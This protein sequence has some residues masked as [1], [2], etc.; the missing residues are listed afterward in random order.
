M[1]IKCSHKGRDAINL[2]GLLRS[3][4]AIDNIPVYLKDIEPPI[5][6]Y[7]NTNTVASR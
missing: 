5:I 4:S 2:P 1:K 7:Q 3:E 6:S